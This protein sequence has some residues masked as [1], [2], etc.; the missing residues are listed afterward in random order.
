MHNI[1]KLSSGNVIVMTLSGKLTHADYAEIVPFVAKLIKKYKKVRL[2]IEL[3]NFEGWTAGAT[4]DDIIFIFR[5]GFHVERIA[6]LVHAAQ[7]KLAILLDRPFGRALSENVKYFR[8][9]FCE[10]AWAWVCDGAIDV[11]DKAFPQREAQDVQG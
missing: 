8:H 9:K 7:D 6:F 3:D 10:E 1:R 4:F 11:T 2:V 5:Y